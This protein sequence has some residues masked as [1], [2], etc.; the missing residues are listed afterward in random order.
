[1]NIDHAQKANWC[2]YTPGE[3]PDNLKNVTATA[4]TVTFTIDSSVKP[5]LVHL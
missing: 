1:M 4:S 5:L 2:G 3:M